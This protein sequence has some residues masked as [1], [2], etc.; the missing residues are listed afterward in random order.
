MSRLARF[1]RDSAWTW[2]GAIIVIVTLSGQTQ[3]LGLWVTGIA[4]VM[5]ILSAWFGGDE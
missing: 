5:H 1:I 4:F 2:C 3:I